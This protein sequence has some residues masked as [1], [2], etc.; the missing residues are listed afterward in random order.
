MWNMA[1][2]FPQHHVEITPSDEDNLS[3]PMIIVALTDGDVTLVDEHD[4]A[5]TYTVTA[6]WHS[7]IAAKRVNDTGT[8]A[9][10]IG[11]Y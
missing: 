7:Y 8:D 10:V 6:G 5:I 4:T 2:M 3:R 11:V 1:Q 9:T